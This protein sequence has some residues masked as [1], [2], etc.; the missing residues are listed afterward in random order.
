MGGLG[1]ALP[2]LLML[3]AGCG[4]GGPTGPERPEGNGGLSGGAGATERLTGTW[5][6]V[7]V[8]SVPGDIQTWTTIWRFEPDGACLQTVETESLA[9][10]FPRITERPCTFVARDFD[11][12]ISF[13]GGG[14]LV[15]EYSFADFSPDRLIL[16]GF[17][18][19]RLA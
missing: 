10:G 5:R 17:E 13:I 7:V 9:E 16:D 18:Y 1:L 11:V 15:F 14:T 3:L 19:Q 8:V 2:L 6:T 12:S 4:D